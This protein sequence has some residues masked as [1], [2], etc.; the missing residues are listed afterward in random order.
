M[1]LGPATIAI[2]AIHCGKHEQDHDGKIRQYAFW[3][4]DAGISVDPG[5]LHAK[6]DGIK[7]YYTVDDNPDPNLEP[8]HHHFLHIEGL[9]IDLRIPGDVPKDKAALLIKGYLSLKEDFYKR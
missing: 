8:K 6:G 9:G 5:V 4:F 7:Y 3:G 2:T 1:P